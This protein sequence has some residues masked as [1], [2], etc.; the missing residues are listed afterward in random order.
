MKKE[1]K[2]NKYSKEFKLKAVQMIMVD[3]WLFQIK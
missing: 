3:T 2:A 1:Q